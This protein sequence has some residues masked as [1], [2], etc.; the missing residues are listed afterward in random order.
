MGF[1]IEFVGTQKADPVEDIS[2]MGQVR[3][4]PNPEYGGRRILSVPERQ[5]VD[6]LLKRNPPDMPHFQEPTD[7]LSAED[8]ARIQALVREEMRAF[9]DGNG[10]KVPEH[11]DVFPVDAPVFELEE[12]P[13]ADKPAGA[14]PDPEYAQKPGEGLS[15]DVAV[16]EPADDPK[17]K[18]RTNGRARTKK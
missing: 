6:Q 10:L 15:A 7:V 3:F 9:A 12:A 8:R 17:P 11:W 2:G 4:A 5:M 18:P 13:S 1:L 16:S 14:A